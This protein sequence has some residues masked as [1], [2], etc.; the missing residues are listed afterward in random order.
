[1][2][3]HSVLRR[4]LLY[5]SFLLLLLCAPGAGLT[6]AEQKILVVGDSISAGYGLDPASGWVSLLDKQLQ[7]SRPGWQVV[8][9]SISGDTTSGGLERLPTLLKAHKPA[10]VILELGGNDGLRGQPIDSIRGNLGQMISLSQRHDAR[11]LL[12]GMQIP[13]N[14]GRRYTVLFHDT[15]RETAKTFDIPVVDFLLAGVAT[16]PELMQDDRI[17]PTAEA[18]PLILDNVLPKLMLLLN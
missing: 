11:V 7:N 17:H 8:N 6:A 18:Q 3:L 13:P 2:M 16:K 12:L 15:F 14:Y 4:S 5:R 10:V 9:A 1:M